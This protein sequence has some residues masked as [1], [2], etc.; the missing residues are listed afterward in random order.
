MNMRPQIVN[1]LVLVLQD[2][3]KI[4]LGVIGEPELLNRAFVT[5][6][7]VIETWEDVHGNNEFL[8]LLKCLYQPLK[9]CISHGL[10]SFFPLYVCIIIIVIIKPGIEEN[11]VQAND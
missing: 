11:G 10:I 6:Y 2:N 8:V 3:I 1:N 7:K 4:P 9:L 5:M